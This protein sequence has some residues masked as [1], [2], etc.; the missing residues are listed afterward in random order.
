[1]NGGS[2]DF[3]GAYNT[4]HVYER[5]FTGQGAALSLACSDAVFTDNS[6]S[7]QV[8]VRCA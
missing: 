8:E 6:G 1:V 4:N 2:A 5:V 3:W 7:V